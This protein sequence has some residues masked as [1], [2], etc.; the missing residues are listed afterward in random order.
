VLRH[1]EKRL[2]EDLGYGLLLEHDARSGDP[3]QPDAWYSYRVQLGPVLQSEGNAAAQPGGVTV[4]GSALLALA[5]DGPLD[6][7]ARVQIKRLMRAEIDS[8]LGRRP[9]VSRSLFRPRGGAGN[10]VTGTGDGRRPEV[11]LEE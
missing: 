10:G 5:A 4:R 11:G 2:L 8:H 9:L 7:D 1:F 6:D 3:V